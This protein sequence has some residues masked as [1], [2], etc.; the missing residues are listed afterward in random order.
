MAAERSSRAHQATDISAAITSIHR[1]SYARELSSVDTVVGDGCVASVLRFE[2][3]AGG[4]AGDRGGRRRRRD[5]ALRRDGAQPR[6]VAARRGRADDRPHRHRVPVID[7]PAA[8]GSS[9]R[10]SSLGLTQRTR[11]S[12]PVSS[13]SARRARAAARGSASAGPPRSAIRRAS[14]SARMPG[15]VDEGQGAQVERDE[16]PGPVEPAQD[17]GELGCAREV[18]LP[19]DRHKA[20]G[21]QLTDGDVEQRGRAVRCGGHMVSDRREVSTVRERPVGAARSPSCMPGDSL[22]RAA[23][24]E[25]A[26]AARL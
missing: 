12:V 19:R 22:A 8:T 25:R 14:W 4:A 2:V 6:G 9:S 13:R 10:P 20:L 1:V 5:A 3:R 23:R 11:S 18:E 17:A 26:A 21:R 15:D 24:A 16:L 7:E